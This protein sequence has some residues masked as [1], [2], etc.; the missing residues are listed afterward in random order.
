[1]VCNPCQNCSYETM[2]SYAYR[3]TYVVHG[4]KFLSISIGACANMTKAMRDV[5]SEVKDMPESKRLA[6]LVLR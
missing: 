1:M 6:L 4:S 2:K 3:V 5:A